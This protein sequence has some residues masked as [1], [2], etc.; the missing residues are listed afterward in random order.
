VAGA[1]CGLVV[2]APGHKRY[3]E[4][5]SFAVPALIAVAS[6]VATVYAIRS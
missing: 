3:P 6:L 5:M 2:L 1:L 4:W